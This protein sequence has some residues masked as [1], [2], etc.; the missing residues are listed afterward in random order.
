MNGK[1]VYETLKIE[2]IYFETENIVTASGSGNSSSSST[3]SNAGG[4]PMELPLDN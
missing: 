1:D 2:T 4:D 3:P